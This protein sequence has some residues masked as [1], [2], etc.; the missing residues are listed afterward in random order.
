MN[1]E[2]LDVITQ[3][4]KTGGATA[5]TVVAIIYGVQILT[6]IL[7]AFVVIKVVSIIF[8]FLSSLIKPD[9]EKVK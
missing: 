3:L 9:I 6:A 1:K 7:K 2:I 8:R 5:S 4:I